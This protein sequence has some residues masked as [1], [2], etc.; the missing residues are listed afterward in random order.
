MPRKTIYNKLSDKK[1]ISEICG[2]NKI[3]CADF[4]EYLASTDHAPLTIKGYKN[5]LD[6]FFVWNMEYNG[7]KFFIDIKKREIIRFQG[8]A[9]NVWRWSPNRIRRMKSVISS[10]SSYIE[11]ILQDEDET[12]EDFKPI[13][14]KIKSPE[15]TPVREKTILT[16]EQVDGLLAELVENEKYQQACVLALAA[17]SGARKAELLQFKVDF[18]VDENIVFDAL[19]KT[20]KIRT[21]GSG[22]LGKQLEKYV[23]I[24]FKKYFDLWMKQR[25]ELG[26]DSE[27]LFVS[28][29]DKGE[30][31]QMK[32]SRLDSFARTFSRQLGCDF[33][34]HCVRHYLV[35]RMKRY[36]IPDNIIQEYS[37]WTSGEMVNVYSDIDASDEF[38]KYFSK[39]GLIEGKNGTINDL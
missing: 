29:D 21:K 22:Q 13:V 17:M 35:T 19:Y 8:H 11:D 23:L 30:W 26:I 15:R 37:G 36:N 5:D 7:N 16:D 38:G 24:D 32:I 33:Y 20:P 2:E 34:W 12:F 9:L 4:I 18:F 1:R 14:T 3:L 10:L 25:E 31:A 28:P 6:I 39:D 27:W